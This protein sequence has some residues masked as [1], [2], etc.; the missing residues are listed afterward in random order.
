MPLKKNGVSML[1][2]S[3]ALVTLAF[4]LA[5]SLFA[6]PTK[7]IP[8]IIKGEEANLTT[9]KEVVN[10]EIE[11]PN[12]RTTNCTATIVGK[13][14]LV[15]AAHCGTNGAKVKFQFNG[16][17]YE[18]TLTRSSLYPD[19]DHD[20]AAVF[21]TAEIASARPRTIGGKAVRGAGIDILGFGCTTVG[22]V[23]DGKLRIGQSLV[24]GFSAFYMVTSSPDGATV[25]RGDSGGPAFV[26]DG[27]RKLLLGV[28]ALGNQTDM[29]YH[30][31]LD[32]TESQT[33]LQKFATDNST[34]ICGINGFTCS[35]GGQTD[36]KP[37]CTLSAA[38]NSVVLGQ[39][40]TLSLV[41]INATKA[42]VAGNP[43]TVPTWS[44]QLTAN[45]LGKFTVNADVQGPGG[46]GACSVTYEVISGGGGDKPMCTLT[47]VPK[48]V[49]P[50][51]EVVLELVVQGSATY[52]SIEGNAVTV[53]V[54]RFTTK[55]SVVGDYSLAG[56]VR[57]SGGSSNCYADFRVTNG[58]IPPPTIPD[59]AVTTSHCGSNILTSS[60]VSTVCL[61]VIKKPDAA[62]ALLWNQV[63]Q[64]TN[65]DGTV[66]VMP[67]LS[68]Q[69][70][71]A[72]QRSISLYAN[73]A[74]LSQNFTV[75]DSK[76]A[77]LTV[78]ASNVPQGIEG[79][80]SKGRYFLVESMTATTVSAALANPRP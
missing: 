2:L 59:Y 21:T 16:S 61:A 40:V 67:I 6:A 12:S 19:K 75:L 7:I 65:A 49:K 80:S 36:P 24:S 15:T 79:R 4:A 74:V 63:V 70:T 53:P 64:V 56:F 60:G 41:T 58:A 37:A 43:A 62:N 71:A 28:N 44:S 78:N 18:G 10:I 46:T 25:C 32:I 29:S 47:A 17:N 76:V 1:S 45:S 39:K 20:L 52:A 66:E 57:G 5:S 27:T 48:Q 13:R 26:V 22:G 8:M 30:T 35:D 73:K 68:V 14:V 54:G 31:R 23:A 69:T 42:S 34:N 72:D 33:F 9:W 11:L 55:K 51:Q 50:N 38:P 3:K 77:T